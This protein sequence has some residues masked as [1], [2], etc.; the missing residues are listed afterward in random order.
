MDWPSEPSRISSGKR[1]FNAS[2]SKADLTKAVTSF[3]STYA[4]TK[5]ANGS[6]I[7]PLILP[8]NYEMADPIFS[9]DFRLSKTFTMKERYKVEIIG[10]MFNSFN[11]ANLT[12]PT[13]AYTIDTVASNPAAQ[14]FAF[15]QPTQRQNQTFGSGGPRAVQVGARFSF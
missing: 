15:G 2:C 12:Y 14:T 13:S 8:S 11:I 9:Q 3:N 4:G 10:E 1:C 5:N 7:S 6:V